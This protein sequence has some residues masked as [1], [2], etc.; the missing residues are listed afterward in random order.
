LRASDGSLLYRGRG[1]AQVQLR[2]FRVEPGEVAAVLARHPAVS[3]AVVLAR[4]RS[5][6][7]LAGDLVLTAY[8]VPERSSEELEARQEL[9]QWLARHLP[10]Y[11]LPAVFVQ[12]DALPLTSQGKLD[13]RAL[14]DP[15]EEEEQASAPSSS[16]L[17][18]Q[19]ALEQVLAQAWAEAL[20]VPRVGRDD[21]FFDLGGHSLLALQ[22]LTWV[23]ETF[24]VELP[25]RQLFEQPTVAGLARALRRE[26][27]EAVETDAEALLEILSLSDDEVAAE[28]EEE[29][30]R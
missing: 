25:I 22:V 3:Q 21:S 23:R 13:V 7:G 10:P 8:F 15:W 14:P 26:R 18:P 4:Q 5:A 2:G 20:Q 11:M 24:E 12:L 1:D 30:P 29:V 6:D 16:H 19:G 9:R 17:P 27:G 28:L